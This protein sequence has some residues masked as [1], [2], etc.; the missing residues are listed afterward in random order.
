MEENKVHIVDWPQD[1]RLKMDHEFSSDIG[2]HVSEWPKM[3][4]DVNMFHN[5]GETIPICIKVCEPICAESS[6]KIGINLMGQPFA[7]IAIRGITKLFNCASEKE[8]PFVNRTDDT[9]K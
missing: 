4:L 5:R 9:V 2:M 3:P 8:T 7:E 6:Y 1:Q